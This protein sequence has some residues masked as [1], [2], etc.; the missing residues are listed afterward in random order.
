MLQRLSQME[1]SSAY[2]YLKESCDMMQRI[3]GE[4]HKK[5][6][7]KLKEE[8]KE[9]MQAISDLKLENYEL[10][11]KLATLQSK[12]KN[13]IEEPLELSFEER[14]EDT[15]ETDCGLPSKG[16]R[17]IYSPTNLHRESPKPPKSH[18]H[19]EEF[20]NE[21]FGG[22]THGLLQSARPGRRIFAETCSSRNAQNGIY[23][24]QGAKLFPATTA[25]RRRKEAGG[26]CMRFDS[27]ERAQ[28]ASQGNAEL[29]GNCALGGNV[30]TERANRLL[31]GLRISL[32]QKVYSKLDRR[33]NA[34][35]LGSRTMNS[36]S[37]TSLSSA[38]KQNLNTSLRKDE[39]KR[40]TEFTSHFNH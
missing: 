13:Y 17:L 36:K 3:S 8:N 11:E 10:K 37:P 29:D 14:V 21:T 39:T 20:S 40:E 26:K 30:S 2:S 22:E 16:T 19:I 24:T 38:R 4:L 9:L 31:A 23:S 27:E 32:R 25:E 18:I 5:E 12:Q 28:E 34:S 7:N 6:V 1:D 33:K 15:P 35:P